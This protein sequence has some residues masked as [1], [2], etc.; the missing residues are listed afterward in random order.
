[1]NLPGYTEFSFQSD[2]IEHSVFRSLTNGPGVLLMH[3]LPGMTPEF[4]KLAKRIFDA[5]F[6]V[7][8]PLLFGN[9]NETAVISDTFHVCISREFKC[10]ANHESSP[11]TH[12][13]R[14]LS[15]RIDSENLGA[16]GVGAIGLCLTGGFVLSLMIEP[17]LMAP[18][19]SEPAL[20]LLAFT[21]EA[22]AALGVDPEELNIAVAREI[23]LLG[24][25][26]SGD[27]ICPELRFATLC[28]RFGNKF[29]R[30]E[31]D[32]SPG[33]KFGIRPRAHAVLTNDYNDA[34]GTP[35]RAALE[36]IISFLKT[37]LK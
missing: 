31:I 36:R 12:W 29:E 14:A 7:F 10:L 37:N 8:L 35:T 13:L 33:N 27:Q 26:F 28:A 20:P 24:L 21:D 5:G 30:I 1:M 6:T 11:I 4:L 23:P 3:E 19:I 25:R 22:K 16:R 15:R 2:N 17:H 18:V 9:P 34:V 32:S